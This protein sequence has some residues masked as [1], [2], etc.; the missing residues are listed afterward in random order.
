MPGVVT[1]IIASVRDAGIAGAGGAGFP[2][3]VKLG[4]AVDTVIANGSECEPV[5]EADRHLLV[6]FAPRVVRGLQAAMDATGARSGVLAVKE[7]NSGAV[8]ASQKAVAGD[9]RLRLELLGDYYPA[10]DEMVLIRQ[11]TGRMVP[12]GQLPFT[13]GVTVSNVTTFAQ[14]ADALDGMPVTHRL[15]TV[16][17]AVNRP[18]TVDTPVGTPI[19]DL[20]AHAGGAA[21]P[22]YEVVTGGPI[23][24]PI[25]DA[26]SP[27]TKTM[28]G[29]IVLPRGHRVLELKRQPVPTTK[30]RAKMCCT[31]QE[32]TILCPRNA[33]GHPISPAKM[34][35]RAWQID[36]IIRRIEAHDL[37]AATE[38]MVFEALLCCRCGICEQYAC[39]FGLS[40]NKVYDLVRDAVKRA[41]LKYDF[42]RMPQWEG[43]MFEYRQLPAKLLALKL[44]LGPYLMHTSYEPLGSITPQKVMIPLVQH[45]GAPAEPVVQTGGRVRAGDLI[46]EIPSGHLGARVH[47]SIDGR[48]EAVTAEH[49]VISGA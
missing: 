17:G 29:V 35:T 36:D 23:M 25:T 1:D 48:V 10:G 49:I 19:S 44:E 22:D 26:A 38:Q 32:C 14:V 37:D 46:G 41:G 12:P 9:P 47:A 2:L 4:N 33:I 39:I 43:V 31:C 20:I 18:V 42:E 34:M 24:G 45:I 21:V 30:L 13:A 8:A 3:H 6:N 15:V 28:G 16:G 11:V 5:I 7:K 27:V 40:P